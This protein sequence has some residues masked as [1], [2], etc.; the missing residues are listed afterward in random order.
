[1]NEEI[2]N[3]MNGQIVFDKKKFSS[4]V[5]SIIARGVSAGIIG[6]LFWV[7]IGFAG[8]TLYKYA[9]T[10]YTGNVINLSVG[11]DHLTGCEYLVSPEG[12]MTRRM[13][14]DGSTQHGCRESY[15]R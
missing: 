7:L 15:R 13:D 10:D 5:S 4:D 3:K 1:M 8:Y 6:A 12:H 14:S 2:L 11:R 9:F